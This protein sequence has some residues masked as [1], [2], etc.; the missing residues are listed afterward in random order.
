MIYLYPHEHTTDKNSIGSIQAAQ[1]ER[2]AEAL[3]VIDNQLNTNEFF[4]GSKISAC[5]FFFFMLAEWSLHLEQSPLTFSNLRRYLHKMSKH[6]TICAVCELEK[7]D[8]AVF[9]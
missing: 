9:R 1:E 8:L 4:L 7:I 2:I 3:S 6:P 5:D